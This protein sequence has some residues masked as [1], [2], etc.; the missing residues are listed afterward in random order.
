MARELYDLTGDW[1]FREY[2]AHARRMRDLD[3]DDWLQTQVPSSIY[4][5]LV[6]VGQIDPADLNANP[7]RFAHI[8][9]R[10]WIFRKV[11]DAPADLLE[12]GRI[13][14]VFDGLDTVAQIWLND[15]LIGKPDNMFIAHRFNITRLLKPTGNR[16]LVKLSPAA[17]HA[18][19]L[20][21]RYGKLTEFYFGSACRSYIRKAQ[22]QFGWDWCPSLPGCGIF[23]PVRLEGI[24][25]A[26]IQDLHVRTIDCSRQHADVAVAVRL[27]TNSPQ[28]SELRYPLA[29]KLSLTGE[30]TCIEQTLRFQPGRNN[31]STIIRLDNPHL[32]QPNG[33]GSP[34]LYKLAVDIYSGDERIDH[35][36]RDVGIRTVHLN[37]TK[38]RHG[39]SFR[40]EVNHQ[41]V[42]V[43]GANWIPLTI[44]PGSQ[45]PD[46]YEAL[47]TAAAGANINMLRVWGGGYYE[48]PCFYE[49]CDRLGIMVWQDFMFACSYYPDRKWFLDAVKTEAA[50]VIKRLRSHPSL[51]LWC[52]NNE[53]DWLHAKGQLGKGKKFYGKAIYHRLLGDL[54][55]ELDRERDYI[56][57]TPFSNTADA[58][59]PGSG[60]I[61]QWDVWGG[62][63]PGRN[64][65]A[66]DVARFVTEFGMQSLPDVD[67]VKSFCI[68]ESPVATTRAIEKHNYQLDGNAR[69]FH[70]LSELFDPPADLEQLVYLTQLAQARRVKEYV[71]YLRAHNNVNSGVL[72]WQFNDCCPAISW[73]AVDCL[74][75]PKALYFYAR[76]FFAG[77]LPTLL[78]QSNSARPD[79]EPT[80]AS[81]RAVVVNDM[82][83]PLAATLI[84]RL[85]DLHGNLLDKVDLAMAIGPASTSTPLRLPKA[86]VRPK[87]PQQSLLQM[88]LENVD[89]VIVQNNFLYLPDKYMD[90]PKAQITRTLAQLDKRKW[91]ITLQS[92][93]VVKD[94]QVTTR[95]PAQ[96]SDNYVDLMPQQR[97]ELIVDFARDA[98]DAENLIALQWVK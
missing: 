17:A 81:A 44:F 64:Y 14:L 49:L 8:S 27:D 87:N 16:L 48:D 56:G 78:T 88:T 75:K 28:E 41:P 7:Q 38:D 12:C 79:I 67:T 57:T 82:P 89:G 31:Q 96:L 43:R 21:N 61:H 80:L 30:D 73:S 36:A 50:A 45:K 15:K 84:C 35:V 77:V 59:D 1:E 25:G 4:T 6:G 86:L 39:Q 58:N 63:Q 97:R 18:E 23:R 2:P 93:T 85:M 74:K 72:F 22:Y 11:F 26:R 66:G 83:E 94:V 55:S 9:R 60:T 52:G 53:I 3:G 91:A 40:F 98:E 19:K 34:S 51:V 70:Y 13:D 47:L 32:W 69:L 92:D 62:N 90:W 54:L 29:C 24:A 95:I 10:P 46:D 5:C 76:R 20:M 71:E 68:D 37:R 33:Y 65:T 42:Y